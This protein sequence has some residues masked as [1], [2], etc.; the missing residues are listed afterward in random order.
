MC[1]HETRCQDNCTFFMS[2]MAGKFSPPKKLSFTGNLSENWNKWKK[3]LNLYLTATEAHEKSNEVKTSRPLKAIGNKAR[4]VY[5]TFT[6][7]NEKDSTK[8]DIV[9]KKFDEYMFLKKN[10]TYM[11][12]KFFAYNQDEGQ[13]IDEYVTE[14]KSRSEHCEFD[15]FKNSSIRD[16]IV[17]GRD[18]CLK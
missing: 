1:I 8:L 11:R 14:Y 3:Q 12:Q 9:L 13:P 15:N 7:D 10:I 18:L 2:D 6:F 17:L 16:K 4:D 5:Y